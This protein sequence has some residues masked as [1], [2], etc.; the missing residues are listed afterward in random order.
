MS[1][2]EAKRE[3]PDLR[4]VPIGRVFPHELHDEQRAL[5]LLNTLHRDGILKS[6]IL[7]TTLDE[8]E[9]DTT[10]MILDA[11]TD[12]SPWTCLAW[13][14]RWCRWLNIACLLSSC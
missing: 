5:P 12:P 2:S 9:G 11:P 14:T 13:G 4:I 1:D 7:V 6:P 10:Y 8:G 3:Y